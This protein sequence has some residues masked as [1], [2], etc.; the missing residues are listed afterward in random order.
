MVG[1]TSHEGD[2]MKRIQ[3]WPAGLLILLTVATISMAAA[4]AAAA[5]HKPKP[6]PT[7]PPA[8]TPGIDVSHWQGTINWAQ[9][10]GAGKQFV[11][12]KA[13]EG[14]AYADPTYSGN[15]SGA[16]AAGIKVGA[17]HFARPDSTPGDAVAE[18]Q[19]F[20]SKA[21]FASDDLRPVLDIEVNGG[22]SVSA[23]QQ[24]VRDWLDEVYRLTGRRATVYTSPSF[25]S[26]SMGNTQ[27]IALAGYT[28]LWIAHWNVSSPTVPAGNW[29][30]FGWSFWQY[31]STGSVSGISGNVDL[32]RANGTDL[33]PF[34]FG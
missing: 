15:R 25:W 22:L 6:P 30:G 4:P 9:V 2:G 17:Y 16:R 24:W 23:L 14:S 1:L 7:P 10:A 29:A 27:S 8:S 11:F 34:L 21:V 19:W 26:G 5:R 3:R 31:S 28:T 12:L 18:A 32:D 13:T 33:T 20:L